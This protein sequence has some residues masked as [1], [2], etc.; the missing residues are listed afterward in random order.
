[1][2]F[3][4]KSNQTGTVISSTQT[5]TANTSS[6]TKASLLN[7]YAKLS[8]TYT[9]G[10]GKVSINAGQTVAKGTY[11]FVC[12]SVSYEYNGQAMNGGKVTLK[13]KVTNSTSKNAP[14][15][16]AKGT[17]SVNASASVTTEGTTKYA[18]NGELALT[19]KNLPDGYAFDEQK[20]VNTIE[21][22]SSGY[23]GYEKRFNWSIVSD[24]SSQKLVASLT[25][26]CPD[27]TYTF[28]VTPKFSDADKNNTRTAKDLK[29]KV[30][31]YSGT[32]SVS[33]SA[34]GKLNLIDRTGE[35]T[36]DNS[37]VCTPKFT[38]LQGQVES[39]ALF[40]ADS[41]MPIYGTSAVSSLF[42]V[43]VKDGLL[44][45]RA[46]EGAQLEDNKT[47]TLSVWMKVKDYAFDDADG[48]TW[49]SLSIKTAQSLPKIVADPDTVTLYLSNKDRT[50]T[51]VI[52]KQTV[53]SERP[54][55]VL[56]SVSLDEKDTVAL[57]SFVNDNGVISSETQADGSLKV[58]LKLK[59]TVT[60]AGGNTYQVKL[61]A[62]FA[63]QG[64]N[65]TGTLITVN[66]KI[67]N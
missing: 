50:A 51:F 36:A 19:V 53:K 58:T 11:T 23:A 67:S 6:K 20:T 1:M 66:V 27:G 22:V 40:D 42:A 16:S 44:Y 28:I 35:A 29:F 38:N 65:T 7:E 24:D 37:V 55:G 47:Y 63:G 13:V 12:N 56:E 52:D 15:V 17:L 14:K 57:A 26:Y 8:V 21:C 25:Q 41:S 9:N 30:K 62:K 59:D 31:V 2:T 5:F 43:T 61:Y 60:Y 39:A 49:A 48:G 18:D 64:T 34:S 10:K 45:V 54:A 46:K 3:G 4:L 33:L 32:V